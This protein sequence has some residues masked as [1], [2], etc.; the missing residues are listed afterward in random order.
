M[1]RHMRII[2]CCKTKYQNEFFENKKNYVFALHDQFLDTQTRICFTDPFGYSW[3]G[4]HG[5]NHRLPP[6]TNQ[7]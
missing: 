3:L 5:V 1:N 4:L 2:T 7:P 6:K